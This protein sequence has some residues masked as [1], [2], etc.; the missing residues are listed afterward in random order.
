MSSLD[1]E[2]LTLRRS[3]RIANLQRKHLELKLGVVELGVEK[4]KSTI[5]PKSVIKKPRS[6]SKSK[7]AKKLITD[8]LETSDDMSHIK[9]NHL[10]ALVK[11]YCHDV[12]DRNFKYDILKSIIKNYRKIGIK[13]NLMELSINS[14]KIVQYLIM[15]T[16]FTQRTLVD[17]Q[18]ALYSILSYPELMLPTQSNTSCSY[19]IDDL[20]NKINCINIDTPSVDLASLF[21][22]CS[23]SD[24]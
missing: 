11:K 10:F 6:V 14:N 15:T 23:L 7:T 22:K 18:D 12:D 17:L 20:I 9:I 2:M 3:E 21:T 1:T 19:T 13:N 8:F 24:T 4:K 16:N 5:K